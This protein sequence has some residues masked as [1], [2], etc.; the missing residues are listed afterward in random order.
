[1]QRAGAHSAPRQCL[2]K[3]KNQSQCFMTILRNSKNQSAFYDHIWYY[4]SVYRYK[5]VEILSRV[6]SAQEK[7]LKSIRV[8]LKWTKK[9]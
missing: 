4:V 5:K 1:M 8:L 7:K 2:K 6:S 3:F 9:G